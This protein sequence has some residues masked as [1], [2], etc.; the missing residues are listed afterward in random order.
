M[1]S[2]MQADYMNLVPRGKVPLLAR[3][4]TTVGIARGSHRNEKLQLN[5]MTKAMK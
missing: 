2:G 4:T 1:H 5:Q 3:R